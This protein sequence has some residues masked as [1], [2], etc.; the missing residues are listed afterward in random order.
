MSATPEVRGQI[1]ELVGVFEGRILAVGPDELTVWL[2]GSPEKVDDFEELLRPYGIVALQR[3][4][5]VALPKLDRRP[6]LHEA[7]AE[8]S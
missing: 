1:I 3:T 7:G 5:R 4:G 2:D 6:H 8:V